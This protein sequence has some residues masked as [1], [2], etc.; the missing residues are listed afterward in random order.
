MGR[1]KKLC[2]LLAVLLIFATLP[3]VAN[4]GWTWD[5]AATT[6]WTW[7]EGVAS[8]DAFDG[9]AVDQ[10]EQQVGLPQ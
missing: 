7:D 8:Q 4:A 10:A 6:G 1:M 2:V 5:E 3:A 9:Y